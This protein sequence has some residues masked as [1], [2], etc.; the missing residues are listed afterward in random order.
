MSAI[1]MI[2]GVWILFANIFGE[3]SKLT[4]GQ[5]AKRIALG[6]ALLAIGLAKVAYDVWQILR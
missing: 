2:V 1:L 6:F 4:S 3:T 5:V